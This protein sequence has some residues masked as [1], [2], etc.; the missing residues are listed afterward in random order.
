MCTLKKKNYGD[1]LFEWP[2]QGNIRLL[3]VPL[4]DKSFWND[5][6]LAGCFS[7]WA[8][9][10]Q[11]K[12]K[13]KWIELFNLISII[14]FLPAFKWLYDTNDVHEGATLRWLHYFTEQPTT[15]AQNACFFE[16]EFVQA[17]KR[18]YSNVVVRIREIRTK[19]VRHRRRDKRDRW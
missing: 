11:T 10:L 14:S 9:H 16:A 6:D 3:D 13:S 2:R 18:S 8:T 4:V 1:P 5:D 19:N 7:K 12:M 15:A 17:S